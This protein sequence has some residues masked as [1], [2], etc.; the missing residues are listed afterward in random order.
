MLLSLS[1][2][3]FV[4]V[5]RLRLEFEAGFTALTGETGAGKSILLDALLLALGGRADAGSVRAGCERADI[6]AEFDLSALPRARE[7]LDALEL[8]GEDGE[9]LLRRVVDRGGRSRAFVN[10]RPATLAQLRELGEVLVDIHGQHEHQS[11]VRPAAQRQLLDAHGGCEGLACEV[12][13]CHRVWAEAREALTRAEEGAEALAE[14]RDRLRWQV[15]EVVRLGLTVESWEA[16][17]A[18][19]QRLTHAASLIEGGEQAIQ[20]LADGEGAVVDAVAAVSARLLALTAHDTRLSGVVDLLESA[21]IQVDEAVHAL[22]QYHGRLEVDPQ[23]LAEVEAG[24]EAVMT[25]AR[26][27]RC[28]PEELPGRLADWQQR[29][30]TLQGS[31]TAA[32]RRA[33]DSAG[34][35]LHA[36][37]GRLSR[38]RRAAAAQLSASVTAAMQDLAMAGGLFEVVLE[39]LETPSAQGGERV[40]FRVAAHPGV[41][42]AALARVASGGELARLSLAIQTVASEQ[43]EVPTLLFDEVDAGI[44]GA[45]AEVVGRRL[46]RLGETRQVFCITHLPQ[47][48]ATAAH[49]W[50]VAKQ[51][52]DGTTLSSVEVMNAAARVEEIARMLGGARITDT[53]RSHAREMLAQGA[54][55]G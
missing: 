17:Q 36:A 45:V 28:R 38:A 35:A 8:S 25:A 11:L 32:L 49:Q 51:L 1:I 53:T 37:A 10:G 52:R 42:A 12:A 14:E 22:R 2:Q 44:G 15:D 43:V 31:D 41:P 50:R 48:A 47:V 5:D 40:E 9:C 54:A 29:L 24:L 6:C 13:Q 21:R 20:A 46:R 18:E 4:I 33:V 26:R 3:D 7:R 55:P 16:L 30:E 34:D 27:H 23:R 39:P 19:H